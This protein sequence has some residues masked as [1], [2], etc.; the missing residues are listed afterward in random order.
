VDR[1][2]IAICG[3]AAFFALAMPVAVGAISRPVF[4]SPK[5][6]Y[7]ALGDSLTYGVQPAKVDA[8]L[9]PSRFN[10]GFV[11]VFAHRL[12]TLA[13][14]LQVVNYGCPGES[15]RTFV[16]GGCPWLAGGRELHNLPRR[17][18]RRRAGVPSRAPE[19]RQPDHAQPRRQRRTGVLDGLQGKLCLR[20]SPRPTGNRADRLAARIDPAPA[21]CRSTQGHRHRD[22][23]VEQ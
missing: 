14:Q 1:A 12:R 16:A 22:R 2:R 15:T 5:R 4:E 8:G 7:L 3:T 6:Y 23:S 10:S 13:S 21:A 11:D 20:E 18:T 9:P 19:R 17:A